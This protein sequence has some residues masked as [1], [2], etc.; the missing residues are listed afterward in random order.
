M[1]GLPS[2]KRRGVGFFVSPQL[3]SHVSDFIPHS[4]RIA[5]ITVNTLPHKITI[6]NVYAPSQV[7]DPDQDRNRKADFWTQLDEIM[8]THPNSSHLCLTGDLNARLDSHLDPSLE[9]IGRGR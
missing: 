5:E 7:E 3:R 4:P 1:S 9:Y 8:L 2:D 6:I